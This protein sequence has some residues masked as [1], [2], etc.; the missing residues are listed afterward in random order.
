ME[1][2]TTIDNG[3]SLVH[4]AKIG[5]V[6]GSD[7]DGNP[8]KQNFTEESL[9]S[10][11]EKLNAENREILID[12]DHAS[13]KNVLERDTT[14]MG[15]ASDFK[16]EK[17]KGLF[18]KI[19]WSDIGKKLIENRCF[20]WL[21]P[22]F[23]LN[24]DNMSPTDLINIALTNRPAQPDLDPIINSAPEEISISNKE[25]TDMT[26]EEIVE[27][28]KST[29]AEMKEAEKAAEVKEE[30]VEEVKEETL[31]EETVVEEVK[32]EIVEEVKEE[33]KEEVKEEKEEVIKE[34]VLNS[35]P[36]I[37]SDI[38]NAPA[39]KNLHGKEFFDYL[40]KHPEC[41]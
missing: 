33:P 5:E 32:E 8:I 27:L 30:I 12:K 3:E 18:G 41:R 2:E 25:I 38:S 15:F 14:A 40:S 10:I 9:N 16:V 28:I 24:K 37:G 7:K 23:K 11:A 36:V 31:N 26:K 20:R 29:I 4:I 13:M 19:K 22:V 21:S 35:Q 34:E 1:I 39:W 6:I 17:G